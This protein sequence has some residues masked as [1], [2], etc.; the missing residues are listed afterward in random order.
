VF[1]F[2]FI[3][4]YGI[5]AL[6]GT[7]LEYISRRCNVWYC[8]VCFYLSAILIVI[9]IVSLLGK[10]VILWSRFNLEDASAWARNKVDLMMIRNRPIYRPKS[11]ED[12]PTHTRDA[13]TLWR[14]RHFQSAGKYAELTLTTAL[15]GACIKDN[16]LFTCMGKVSLYYCAT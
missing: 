11:R 13:W 7:L 12:Q 1:F 5:G 15:T 10:G 9:P 4:S 2:V 6:L 14:Q 16:F 8:A 3:A